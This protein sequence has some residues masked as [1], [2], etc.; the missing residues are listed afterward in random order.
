MRFINFITTL[1]FATKYR[2]PCLNDEMLED[3]EQ[4]VA[5][6]L[7]AKQGE[8]CQINGEKDHVHMLICVPPS[9][10]LSAI[11]NTLK[12]VTSRQLRQ[13]YA[14]HLNQYYWKP[15]LWSRSY[16]VVSCGGAPLSVLKQYIAQ[17]DRP[18]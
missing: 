11:V 9:V 7:K 12:T 14:G 10:A 1:F 15:V 5:A 6:L 2:R 18:L 17:Q 13:R 4:M 3:L 8:L 16:Y